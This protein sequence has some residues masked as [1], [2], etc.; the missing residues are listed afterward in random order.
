LESGLAH[1]EKLVQKPS[2]SAESARLDHTSENK[3]KIEKCRI[4]VTPKI[5]DSIR[6]NQVSK[7]IRINLIHL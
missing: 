2:T 4:F 5:K 6:L 1:L 7:M 3:Q